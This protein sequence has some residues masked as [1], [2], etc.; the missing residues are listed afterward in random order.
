MSRNS[1]KRRPMCT[2]YEMFISRRQGSTEVEEVFLG[3]DILVSEVLERL[4][5]GT[6]VD[7]ILREC[8][9]LTRKHIHLAV[10]LNDALR[11]FL[12]GVGGAPAKM[13]ESPNF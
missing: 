4:A 11:W 7:D 10:E 5:A 13:E 9:G 6:P 1:E 8:P 12:Y 2:D 3:T